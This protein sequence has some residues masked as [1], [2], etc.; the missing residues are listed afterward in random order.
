MANSDFNPRWS[1]CLFI[2][3]L[4]AFF[5]DQHRDWVA[6]ENQNNLWERIKTRNININFNDLRWGRRRHDVKYNKLVG[7]LSPRSVSM[8][9]NVVHLHLFNFWDFSS[10]SSFIHSYIF[11]N[12]LIMMMM[13]SFTVSSKP[14]ELMQNYVESIN[15][16]I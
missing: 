11:L 5:P 12:L 2:L 7:R 4:R 8:T 10:I 1:V 9:R 16:V 3:I 13:M 15:I 6:N 14:V